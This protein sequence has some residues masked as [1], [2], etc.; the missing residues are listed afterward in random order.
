VSFSHDERYEDCGECGE[1]FTG[2][3]SIRSYMT[4]S[5]RCISCAGGPTCCRECHKPKGSNHR[6]WCA[7]GRSMAPPHEVFTEHTEDH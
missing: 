4:D 6:A 2:E 1:R 5:G 3:A 7:I